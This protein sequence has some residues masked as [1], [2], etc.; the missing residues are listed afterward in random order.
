MVRN[1]FREP[2][3]FLPNEYTSES[4]ITQNNEKETYGG[5]LHPARHTK[6]WYPVNNFKAI[7][8]PFNKGY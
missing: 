7:L 1:N 5:N 3:I 8:V 2:C 4:L 6:K